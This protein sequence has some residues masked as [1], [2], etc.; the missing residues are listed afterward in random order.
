ML[1]IIGVLFI[2]CF[3]LS[4]FKVIFK[5]CLGQILIFLGIIALIVGLIICI[6]KF[7]LWSVIKVLLAVVVILFIAYWIGKFISFISKR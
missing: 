7:G 4:L 5:G 3:V 6:V 1:Y 2:V